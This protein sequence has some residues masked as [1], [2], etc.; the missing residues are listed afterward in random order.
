M[1]SLE[2]R[3]AA[4]SARGWPRVRVFAII[5]G[6]TG[7]LVGALLFY[8]THGLFQFQN[9]P[10]LDVHWVWRVL[11][12]FFAVLLPGVVL[13]MGTYLVLLGATAA[14]QRAVA[15]G[16]SRVAALTDDPSDV[17]PPTA[18]RLPKSA[19]PGVRIRAHSLHRADAD[20]RYT[21]DLLGA[22]A[23]QSLVA[24][25]PLGAGILLLVVAAIYYST[26][27]GEPSLVILLGVAYLAWKLWRGY[28]SH[29]VFL[30]RHGDAD[31]VA[32]V[33]SEPPTR[34]TPV[35]AASG[36]RFEDDDAYPTAARTHED[37][38]LDEDTDEL[39]VIARIRDNY[40]E[41]KK[42]SAAERRLAERA[43]RERQFAER[44]GYQQA[45]AEDAVRAASETD[46][47]R[48]R[49]ERD[50]VAAEER[51]R[52]YATH[53]DTSRKPRESRSWGTRGGH[54]EEA[55]SLFDYA[56]T[57]WRRRGDGPLN[58]E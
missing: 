54:Q 13:V 20:S 14:N 29:R 11:A 5:N 16:Q 32:P 38:V 7:I 52:I 57:R 47:R 24:L 4:R 10:A 51:R 25:A 58:K 42:V 35:V 6:V 37:R 36:E 8:V 19:P 27:Y 40:S 22:L 3:W 23:V 18:L 49:A 2:Q 56:V 1:R 46:A 45:Q 34:A 28:R 50:R 31:D 53:M 48:D 17:A 44:R 12:L 39:P 15:A 30:E 21:R 9:F 41:P 26:G 43:E 33:R 55:A